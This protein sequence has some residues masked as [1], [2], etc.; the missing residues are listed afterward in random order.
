ML[1]KT[2]ILAEEAREREQAEIAEATKNGKYI[3]IDFKP[4]IIFSEGFAEL[5]EQGKPYPKYREN[6]FETFVRRVKEI[7]ASDISDVPEDV[8]YIEVLGWYTD[9]VEYNSEIIVKLWNN[10]L[11]SLKGEET[12]FS[13]WQIDL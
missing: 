9:S 6:D 8:L 2:K 10:Y 7:I 12:D 13:T 5:L 1:E 3:P 11:R 4:N